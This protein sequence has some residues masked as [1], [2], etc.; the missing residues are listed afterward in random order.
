MLRDVFWWFYR[1]LLWLLAVATGGILLQM[2]VSYMLHDMIDC[3]F[4][5]R[6]FLICPLPRLVI[7]VC[8]VL[9]GVVW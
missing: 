3:I 7:N 8:W 6:A 1:V 9:V 2:V 4:S 5:W